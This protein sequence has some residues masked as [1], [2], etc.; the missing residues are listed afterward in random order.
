MRYEREE[1]LRRTQELETAVNDAI[2][3]WQR[4]RDARL[5]RGLATRYRPTG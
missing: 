2:A 1:D 5:G 3:L 4:T